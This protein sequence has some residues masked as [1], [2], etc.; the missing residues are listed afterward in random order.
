MQNRNFRLL[1]LLLSALLVFSC[2]NPERE[3]KTWE[4]YNGTKEGI[5]YS[6]LTQVD[7][8]NVNQLQVAWTYNT[9]DADTLNASQIQCNP[10]V[11]D[12]ILYGVGPQMKLFAIDA[13]TGKEQWVFDANSKT[14]HDGNRRAYHNMINS[15]GVAYWTDGKVDKRIFFTA[16]SNTFAIDAKTGNPITTFGDNGSIDLHNDLDRD[17]HDLFVVNS[18]PGIVYKNLIILGT[19]VDEAPPAAPG[20]IRAY[21]VLTGK[22][23]W[24]FHTIPQ[25]GEFGYETWEDENAWK[26]IGA[27][28]TWSGFSLDEKRGILFAPTGS[29]AYDFY[30]GKRKG[31]NLF[32]NCLLALDASTG[33]RIWHFQFMHHDL[34]DK[35]LPTP[36]T[37]ITIEKDGKTVDAVAQTTKNGMVYVFERETGKP[38]FDIDEVPVDTVSYLVGEKVWPTQPIP[39][40]PAPFVRQSITENDINPYLADSIQARL[41]DD[42]KSYRHGNMFMPPGTTPSIILPGYDGGGEWGGAA[43]DPQTGV[44]YV[45]ANEMAWIMKMNENKMEQPKKESWLQA[46]ERLY[47]QNCMTCHGADRKGTGNNPTVV[48]IRSKYTLNDF[49][50]L[51]ENGRRMMPAFKQFDEQEKNAIASYLLG[52]RA[53]QKKDFIAGITKIDTVNFM[54]YKMSGYNKFLSPDGYPAIS[55]PWGTLNAINLNTGEF[56]WK[57]TLGEYEEF[58]SRGIPPTGTENYGGPVVTAGGLVFIA[59]S[60]DSKFRAFNKVTGKI[61]WEYNLPASGFA[62]PAVYEL[63]GKQ[64]IVIACGGGK[65]GAKSG[66][67][68]LAF[69]L[70]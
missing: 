2:G 44:L 66:D 35:D 30:G 34:W 25:P 36:P 39:R 43:F 29:A 28:N 24:I 50:G 26:H 68:Y 52:M 14:R 33:K 38:I 10:I 15:R 42:L 7:T 9:G 55:P 20:H 56:V 5:K 17:V 27:A 48:N 67:S 6:S 62:T 57:T 32:A 70:P 11:V 45:N 49:I 53:D 8:S 64:Y 4:V 16:G 46:G 58:K 1:L 13:L 37:L 63:N 41:R 18:S 3:Y 21:D 61:V 22:L 60:R 40:K 59:A 51:V 65:L 31:A 47:K 69:A 19:R 23:Q 54:P 12:G